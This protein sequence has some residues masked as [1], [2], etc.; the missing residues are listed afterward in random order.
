M[1]LE[2][3]CPVRVVD[4]EGKERAA[5]ATVL[6]E[7]EELIV[8]GEARVRVPRSAI[9]DAVAAEGTLTVWWDAGELTLELGAAATKWATKLREAPKLVVDKLDVKAGALVS[10]VGIGDAEL[11][12]QLAGRAGRL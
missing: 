10:V 8:R 2:T 6:L 7:S 9:R 5:L 4:A 1:G 11:L 3:R 12:A